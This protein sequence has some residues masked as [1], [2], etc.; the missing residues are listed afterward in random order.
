MQGLVL[1]LGSPRNIIY[2]ADRVNV[3]NDQVRRVVKDK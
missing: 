1:A 3:K 2:S